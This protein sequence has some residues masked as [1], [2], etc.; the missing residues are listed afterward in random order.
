MDRIEKP[1]Q[2]LDLSKVDF[3]SGSWSWGGDPQRTDKF[4][5]THYGEDDA[6]TE[7]CYRVPECLGAMLASQF[8]AG[9]QAALRRV[10][11]ALNSF[12]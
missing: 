11:E 8:K 12:Q 1:W 3:A 5:I 7:T 10:R 6:C 9:G 2:E 4:F